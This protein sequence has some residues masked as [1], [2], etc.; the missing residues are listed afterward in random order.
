MGNSFQLG[1]S[2]SSQLAVGSGKGLLSRGTADCQLLT[3]WKG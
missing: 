1:S 2:V 3:A